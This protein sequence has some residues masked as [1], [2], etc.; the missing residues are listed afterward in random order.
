MKKNFKHSPQGPGQYGSGDGQ[1]GTSASEDDSCR[2]KGARGHV[3]RAELTPVPL[4]R[5]GQT[6]HHRDACILWERH[7][8]AASVFLWKE[9]SG[10]S[11]SCCPHQA[12]GSPSHTRPMLP[13]LHSCLSRQ[14]SLL[15]FS[16]LLLAAG[17]LF[18]AFLSLC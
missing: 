17:F 18:Y 1:R 14:L 13:H 2:P 10:R 15:L 16:S 4:A 8:P 3:A 12:E 7:Q 9:G 6:G 11:P 5:L